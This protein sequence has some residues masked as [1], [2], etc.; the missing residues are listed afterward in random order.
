MAWY[1]AI[2][3]CRGFG[4]PAASRHLTLNVAPVLTIDRPEGGG[5]TALPAHVGVYGDLLR[6]DLVTRAHHRA[7]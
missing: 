1:W 2:G 4:L 6:R 7:S 3:C 5:C